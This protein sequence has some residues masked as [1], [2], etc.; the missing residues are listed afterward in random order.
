MHGSSRDE[1]ITIKPT[2]VGDPTLHGVTKSVRIPIQAQWT[3]SRI[4]VVGSYDVALAD[5]G[6]TP[7]TGFL[8]LSIADHGT[9]E[10]HLLFAKG[11][12]AL[13]ARRGCGRP[14]PR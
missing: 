6:I 12:S 10:L 3:G 8:V 5:Y 1:G 13:R 7:P 14:V 11:L 2:A 4:E 9:I